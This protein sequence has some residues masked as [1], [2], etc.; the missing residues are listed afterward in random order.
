MTV[1]IKNQIK[2]ALKA[3]LQEI[4]NDIIESTLD[5]VLTDSN[6]SDKETDKINMLTHELV[7]EIIKDISTFS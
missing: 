7:D 5:K 4:S 6:F 2:K 3:S 1:K